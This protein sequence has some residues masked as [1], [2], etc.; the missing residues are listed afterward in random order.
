IDANTMDILAA[1]QQGTPDRDEDWNTSPIVFHD[2]SGRQ[3]V[4]A[5]HKDG[6]FYAYDQNDVSAGPVWHWQPGFDT[7]TLSAY[8]PTF[9][10]GGTLF[11][12]S[13][14]ERRLYAIGPADGTERWPSV[15][16]GE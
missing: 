6:K 9:L 4:G 3:L 1:N 10:S 13:A 2:A 8:D 16:I 5:G 7:G 15:F 11:F 12:M 14:M